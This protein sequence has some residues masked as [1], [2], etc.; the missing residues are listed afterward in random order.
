MSEDKFLE[1]LQSLLTMV[2][3]ENPCSVACMRT[4]LINIQSMAQ[5]SGK[6]SRLTAVMMDFAQN[7]FC[8]L[9]DHRKDFAGVPGEFQQNHHKRIRLRMMLT[10]GC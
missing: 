5:Q 9:I 6:V 2:D 4:V 10:P 3:P 8:E 7:R 1:L